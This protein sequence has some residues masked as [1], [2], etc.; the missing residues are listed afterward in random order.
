MPWHILGSGAMGCLEGARLAIGGNKVTLLVRDRSALA[1]FRRQGG[2]DLTVEGKTSRIPMNAEL[3]GEGP[4][5]ESLLVCVKAHQTLAAVGRVVARLATGG[6]LVFMQNGMGQLDEIAARYPELELYPAVTTDGAWCSRRFS[7][8]HAGRGET[9][10]GAY[11]PGTPVDQPVD[12]M[13]AFRTSDIAI[14]WDPEIA[15]RQWQK[16]AVNC[17]V[18]P[19]TALL[20]CRNGDLLCSQAAA[21]L[22]D[23]CDEIESVLRTRGIALGD[24]LQAMVRDVLRRTLENR[25]SMLQDFDAGRETE[26]DYINGYLLREAETLGIDVPLNR[27]LVELVNLKWQLR[28]RRENG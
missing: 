11:P 26:L 21:P 27:Q 19:L 22:V 1:A 7:V 9:W 3:P 28:A 6:R 16:L 12:L 5:I 14:R 24:P 2:V 20:E 23:L 13:E 10:L 4:A 15:T 25:S 18:N 8:I 17:V